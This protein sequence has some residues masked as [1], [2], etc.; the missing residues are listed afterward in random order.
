MNSKTLPEPEAFIGTKLNITRRSDES[1]PSEIS[2]GNDVPE[3]PI[4]LKHP[5]VL[6]IR[7]CEHMFNI[8]IDINLQKNRK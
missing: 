8:E 6:P 3:T 2:K 7:L 4:D 5:A 1:L